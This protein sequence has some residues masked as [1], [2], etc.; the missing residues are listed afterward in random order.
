MIIEAISGLSASRLLKHV[1][2]A[3]KAKTGEE[4]DWARTQVYE[5]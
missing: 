1:G 3:G 5:L 4:A 2:E